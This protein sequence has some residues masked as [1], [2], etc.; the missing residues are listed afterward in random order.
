MSDGRTHYKGKNSRSHRMDKFKRKN[1]V[2]NLQ[3]SSYNEELADDIVNRFS[4]IN[5]VQHG[6]NSITSE[7]EETKSS[8]ETD[9]NESGEGVY[10]DDSDD[11]EAETEDDD[12]DDEND[13]DNGTVCRLSMNALLSYNLPCH[14]RNL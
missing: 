1:N 12:D 6:D 7:V 2:R 8:N 3:Q 14:K 13:N 5:L 10:D 11:S 9:S 4:C